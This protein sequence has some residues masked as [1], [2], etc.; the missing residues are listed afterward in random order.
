MDPA[1]SWS[2]PSPP[3][4]CDWSKGFGPGSS[5]SGGAMLPPRTRGASPA[6][7]NSALTS[8]SSM[9]VPSLFRRG[10]TLRTDGGA[11]STTGDNMSSSTSPPPPPPLPPPS[12]PSALRPLPP[13]LTPSRPDPSPEPRDTDMRRSR[14]SRPPRELRL[15]RLACWLVPRG[16]VVVPDAAPDA[17]PDAVSSPP[18][19]PAANL[20]FTSGSCT[21]ASR[22]AISDS[23]FRRST[24]MVV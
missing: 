19:S 18:S 5:F 9:S 7:A 23:R 24:V 1:T 20:Q 17:A 16:V 4:A 21:N 12:S 11:P 3:V 13:P 8:M 22:T 14:S 10:G 6:R 15:G 2:S